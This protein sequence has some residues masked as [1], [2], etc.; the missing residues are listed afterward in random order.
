[1]FFFGFYIDPI[2]LIVFY[3]TLVISIAA[4]IFMNSTYKKWNQVHNGPDLCGTE[5]GYAIV[6]RTGLGVGNPVSV[7]TIETPELRRLAE[8]QEKGLVTEEEYQAKKIQIKPGVIRDT[9]VNSSYIEFQL[10]SGQ[11]TDHYDPRTHIVRLSED[12]AK[13]HSVAAM[14]IVAHELDHAQQHENT[15]ILI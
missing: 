15:S 6:N 11:L 1:M 7:A 10:V 13:R 14:A 2:Y 5:T 3:V 9:A 8:L 4:Q 12:V